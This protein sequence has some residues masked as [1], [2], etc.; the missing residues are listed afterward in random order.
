MHWLNDNGQAIQALGSVAIVILTG[1][2]AS[3]TWRYVQ[4]T[5]QYVLLTQN[6]LGEQLQAAAARR[7]ELR[8]AADLLKSILMALPVSDDQRLADAIR[9]CYDFLSFPYNQFRA[10]ASEVSLKAASDAALM[11]T[12]L[13]WLGD[14]FHTIRSA[15]PPRSPNEPLEGVPRAFNWN[16]FPKRDYEDKWRTAV[17]ALDR[18]LAELDSFEATLASAGTA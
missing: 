8:T 6:L 11:D 16:K 17:N 2:L 3:I 12:N 9:G 18:I 15:P 14:L 5:S 7:R 4:L 13:K 10:L 1:V